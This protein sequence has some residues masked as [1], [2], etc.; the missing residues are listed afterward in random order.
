MTAVGKNHLLSGRDKT[1]IIMQ[2]TFSSFFITH[3]HSHTHP[4]THTHTHTHFLAISCTRTHTHTLSL[5]ERKT[6]RLK[7][8]RVWKW[9]W[10]EYGKATTCPGGKKQWIFKWCLLSWA[11][12]GRIRNVGKNVKRGERCWRIAL[13]LFFTTEAFFGIAKFGCGTIG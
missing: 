1:V 5:W 11:Q 9:F 2:K 4:L 3:W 12:C 10:A 13:W 7:N 6:E 8:E